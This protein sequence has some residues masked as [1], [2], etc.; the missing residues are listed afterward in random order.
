MRNRAKAEKRDA[1]L[2]ILSDNLTAL[3]EKRFPG[4]GG[5][6]RCAEELGMKQQQWSPWENG[7]RVPNEISLERIASFFG[8]TQ[9]Y[10]LTDHS[11]SHA[12]MEVPFHAGDSGKS[13]HPIGHLHIGVN[14]EMIAASLKNQLLPSMRLNNV[15]A[16]LKLEFSVIDVE[17]LP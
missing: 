15:K 4:R 8:V 17:F 14:Q 6:K 7:V 9:E 11:H 12:G 10:L 5:S 1:M 2:K 13:A 16:V 3:R